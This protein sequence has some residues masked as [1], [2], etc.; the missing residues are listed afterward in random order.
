MLFDA[1]ICEHL[2]KHSLKEIHTL[3]RVL[4]Q[5]CF[6][7]I[8]FVLPGAAPEQ[9]HLRWVILH[10][11]H[12]LDKTGQSKHNLPSESCITDQ[13]CTLTFSLHYLLEFYTEVFLL[14]RLALVQ[15][16]FKDK[17]FHR[18]LT[19]GAGDRTCCLVNLFILAKDV[20]GSFQI[21]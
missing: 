5:C 13:A 16:G 1:F 19:G 20:V 15:V 8:K 9:R 18:L 14:A 4:N 10:L 2:V 6:Q 21:S 12:S 3:D 7:C 17:R 11:S